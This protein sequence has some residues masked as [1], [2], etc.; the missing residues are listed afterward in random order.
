MTLSRWAKLKPAGYLW[1]C[2]LLCLFNGQLSAQTDPQVGRITPPAPSD[3]VPVRPQ[4][5]ELDARSHILLDF[6]SGAILSEHNSQARVEPA[7]ITKIMTSYVVFQELHA[8]SLSLDELVTVSEKAWRMVGSR[9]FIEVGKQV[10]VQDLIRGLVVQSGNDASVALAEHIAGTESAFAGLMNQYAQ[11]LG[12]QDTHYV[13]ATGLPD[14]QHYTTAA[15]VATLSKALIRD[16]PE[17][18]GYYAEREFTFNEVPQSNRNLLLFR[19]ERVDGIKTGHTEAAGYCLAASSVADGMRLISVV[20]GTASE[21]ARAEQT[22]ALL[23]YGHRFYETVQL[24]Q[25]GEQPGQMRV[26][27]GASGSV[28]LQIPSDVFLTIPR[29]RYADL[30]ARMELQEPLLA[31]VAAGQVLGNIV[32]SLDGEQLLSQPLQALTH[33]PEGNWLKRWW[34]GM[35]LRFAGD[36]E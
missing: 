19:D 22:Q 18:Y 24:Y 28:A 11:R 21:A 20:M 33:V 32:I 5:P 29:G 3:P 10:S 36:D 17:Q 14:S 7:S 6:N 13:N 9:M 15:D 4:P 1:L 2:G 31:P 23:N 25:Q 8:G 35:R 27:R 16:F 30:M 26:W 12:M 34:H